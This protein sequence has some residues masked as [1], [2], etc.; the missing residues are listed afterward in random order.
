MMRNENDSL[1]NDVL[2]SWHKW[3][4]GYK[5]VGGINSSPMFRDAKTSKGWDSLSDI[6]DDTLSAA[7]CEGVNFHIFELRDTYRTALQIYARNLVSGVSVWS[8]A[9]LPSNSEERAI[10]LL[11]AKNALMRRLLGAGII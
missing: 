11:E 3:A 2:V 8:S 10:L 1:L 6:T 7:T 5:H 4:C 9:R